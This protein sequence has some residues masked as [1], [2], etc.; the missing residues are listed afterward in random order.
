MFNLLIPTDIIYKL[1]FKI[2]KFITQQLYYYGIELKNINI[3]HC[4][5]VYTYN[6]N[7]VSNSS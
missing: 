7:L 4:I 6:Y 2:I 3:I 5:Q 1:Y